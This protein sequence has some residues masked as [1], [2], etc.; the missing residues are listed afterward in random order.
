MKTKTPS[1]QFKVTEEEHAKLRFLAKKDRRSVCSLMQLQ[2][3]RMVKDVKLPSLESPPKP[4]A[5]E[6]STDDSADVMLPVPSFPSRLAKPA[7]VAPASPAPAPHVPAPAPAPQPPPDG[8]PF[9]PEYCR[10]V[11]E[12]HLAKNP[13]AAKG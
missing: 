1:L 7:R 10:A 8:D 6:L 13:P 5:P 12:A 2:V 11:Y 9:D 3:E 4:L